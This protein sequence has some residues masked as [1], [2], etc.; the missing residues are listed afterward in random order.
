[1]WVVSFRQLL[2]LVV[3]FGFLVGVEAQTIPS[4]K[5]MALSHASAKHTEMIADCATLAGAVSSEHV[6][7]KKGPCKRISF[8]CATQCICPTTLPAPPTALASPIV[9]RLTSYW[10]RL[11]AALAERSIKP[12][13]HPPIAA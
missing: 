11:A 3:G 1:M 7:T 2:I 10:P 9:W 5:L 12:D 6:P 4:A 13:L 8:G